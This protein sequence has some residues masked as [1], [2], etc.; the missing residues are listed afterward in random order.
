MSPAPGANFSG[1]IFPLPG[2]PGIPKFR[3]RNG[4]KTGP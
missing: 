1:A 3:R 2:R 4:Y